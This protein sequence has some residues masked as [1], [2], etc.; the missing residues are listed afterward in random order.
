MTDVIFVPHRL[1]AAPSGEAGDW[2]VPRDW[3]EDEFA[4][5]LESIGFDAY[6]HLEDDDS[7]LKQFELKFEPTDP[8]RHACIDTPLFTIRP[9]YWGNNDDFYA[10]DLPNFVY[11][12]FDYEVRWYKWP[13]RDAHANCLLSDDEW[14]FMLNSM[15]KY[16][17]ELKLNHVPLLP[18]NAPKPTEADLVAIEWR[19]RMR[20]QINRYDNLYSA[21][22]D[23]IDAIADTDDNA[24]PME[25]Y[26][27]LKSAMSWDDKFDG[28]VEL[29]QVEK[30][31]VMVSEK[32][33]TKLTFESK[34][35]S[36]DE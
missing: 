9:F 14:R 4:Q 8:M 6:G 23:F 35:E 27:K 1:D 7:P 24:D 30:L 10:L 13:M 36:H 20:N 34:K 16:V 22:H 3:H 29:T 2:G 18:Q 12:P 32:P 31:M 5:T 28:I 26:E 25:A 15:R 19:D 21:I 11:K 17:D 33:V